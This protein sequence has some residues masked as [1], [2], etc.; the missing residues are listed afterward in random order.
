MSYSKTSTVGGLFL[1]FTFIFAVFLANWDFFHTPQAQ[2]LPVLQSMA[3]YG[4]IWFLLFGEYFGLVVPLFAK[5]KFQTRGGLT[6]VYEGR[7]PE[8]GGMIT[9]FV[10]VRSIY[11]KHCNWDGFTEVGIFKRFML[12]LSPN[13]MISI[14]DK[15][16][17]FEE[18]P[19]ACCDVPEGAIFYHKT[20][21]KAQ[22]TGIQQYLLIRLENAEKLISQLWTQM[23]IT[24]AAMEAASQG[25]DQQLQKSATTLS[26]AMEN[27]DKYRQQNGQVVLMDQQN[28]GRR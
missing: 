24:R 28:Q 2:I 16:E 18:I 22:V 19:T 13:T 9:V 21:C 20:L 5:K 27:L 11:A 6:G 1:L 15:A 25:N 10:T 7:K 26:T 14:T 8:Q 17:F 3:V 4:L 12:Y 23:E